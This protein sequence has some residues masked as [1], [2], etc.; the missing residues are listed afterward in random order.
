MA[1]AALPAASAA[2]TGPMKIAS[3]KFHGEMQAN[4]PRPCRRS[5]L[6]SPVGPGSAVALDELPPRL[7]RIIAQEI[8]RLAHF[9]HGV[10]QRLARLA[11]AQGEQRLALG[12]EQVGRLVQQHRPRL[13]AERIPRLLRTGGG[14]NRD[15]RLRLRSPRSP[16]RRLRYGRTA[17]RPAC[18]RPTAERRRCGP[19]PRFQRIQPPEQ[20]LAHQRIAQVEP[21]AILAPRA[22]DRIGQRD[23]R[24]ALRFQRGKLGHRIAHQMRRSGHP[25]R[26]CG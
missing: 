6:S 23:R 17:R 8:D 24:I 19:Q 26:R 1:I 18:P 14:A 15:D 9:E 11:H 16:G 5:W 4:T 3:G 12:L 22:E 2:A 20:R 10:D 25:R 21:R 7:G 13:A